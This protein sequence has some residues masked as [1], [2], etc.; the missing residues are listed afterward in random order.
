MSSEA[1]IA[2]L[3]PLVR[4]LIDQAKTLALGMMMGVMA[5]CWATM[6]ETPATTTRTTGSTATTGSEQTPPTLNPKG[7][8]ITLPTTDALPPAK[9][10]YLA[11]LLDGSVSVD[12]ATLRAALPGIA[13]QSCLTVDPEYAKFAP[14]LAKH[15]LKPPVYL[16][17]D[18]AGKVLKTGPVTT[19]A[20]IIGARP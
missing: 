4:Y 1:D 18:P 8:A 11:I 12:L 19:E 2:A 5:T 16:Y 20:A 6:G 13:V 3:W 17:Q 14:Y 15:G 10:A 9:A 7:P